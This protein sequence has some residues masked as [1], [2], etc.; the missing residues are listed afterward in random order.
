MLLIHA[1]VFSPPSLIRL[2]RLLH[3]LS[4]KLFFGV[5]DFHDLGKPIHNVQFPLKA[6]TTVF[7]VGPLPTRYRNHF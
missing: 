3:A 1:V 5:L 7:S 4:K 2:F 6:E